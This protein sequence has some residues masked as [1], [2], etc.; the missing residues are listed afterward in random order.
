MVPNVSRI[1]EL[2]RINS[3]FLICIGSRDLIAVVFKE[4]QGKSKEIIHLST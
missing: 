3:I 1:N 4:H 2:L